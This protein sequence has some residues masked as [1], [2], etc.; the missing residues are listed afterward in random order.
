MGRD[1]WSGSVIATS[2]LARHNQFTQRRVSRPGGL[3][4]ELA[5][6][7]GL[8]TLFS[9]VNPSGRQPG[10]FSTRRYPQA[11]QTRLCDQIYEIES[12]IAHVLLLREC[13]A[14]N[15]NACVPCS[16]R[17]LCSSPILLAPETERVLQRA[18]NRRS[19]AGGHFN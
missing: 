6:M 11:T 5:A 12:V 9:Q 17:G 2:R 4:H 16:A 18:K 19:R 3:P 8:S 15:C 7:A 14:H 1:C 10:R 13:K